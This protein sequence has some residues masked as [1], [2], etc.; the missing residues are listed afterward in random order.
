MQA[1]N[2]PYDIAKALQACASKDDARPV[3]QSFCVDRTEKIVHVVSSDTHRMIDFMFDAEALDL[4]AGM[5]TFVKL[6]QKEIIVAPLT[7]GQYPNWRRIFPADGYKAIGAYNPFGG[8]PQMRLRLDEPLCFDPGQ[9]P[10]YRTD[11]EIQ[12]NGAEAEENKEK[13]VQYTLKPILF[14]NHQVR[15]ILMPVLPK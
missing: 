12:V 7:Q 11:Y 1:T 6:S 9:L 15:Y 8:K 2:L 3:M 5:Y 13:G 10:P 14:Q 4:E